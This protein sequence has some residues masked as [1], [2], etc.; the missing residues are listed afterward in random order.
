MTRRLYRSQVDHKIAGVCGGI[1]EYLNIDPTLVR[2][3]ALALI[4]LHGIGLLA[5][6][7]AWI[8]MPKKPLQFEFDKIDSKPS[9]PIPMAPSP[10]RGL[11]PGII[12]IVIGFLILMHNTYWWWFEFEYVL[13]IILIVIGI[14]LLAGMIGRKKTDNHILPQEGMK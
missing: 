3:A 7:I 2:I 5:Y 1:A 14:I 13:P 9:E 4:F 11:I 10:R 6:I 12:L 8:A